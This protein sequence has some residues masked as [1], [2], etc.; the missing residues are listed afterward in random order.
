M[1]DEGN[2]NKKLRLLPFFNFH[3]GIGILIRFNFY[4]LFATMRTK[5]LLDS[6]KEF[7]RREL[8]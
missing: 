3:N 4:I 7:Y 5:K 8:L 1:K 6:L 2:N